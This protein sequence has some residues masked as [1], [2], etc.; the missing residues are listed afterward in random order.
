[1]RPTRLTTNFALTAAFGLALGAA[2]LTAPARA[3]EDGESLENKIFRNILEG[4]GL[5]KDG[6]AINY[7]E[8]PGLVIPPGRDLP[9]PDKGDAAIANNPAWPK[10]PD[11][12]RRKEEA[13]LERERNVSDER[14][15]E[16][17]RLSEKELTPGGN[18]RTPPSRRQ[19]NR[20]LG[21]SVDERGDRMTPS[22]L[23][24]K[25]GLFGNMFGSS[26]DEEMAKFTGERPRALLTDPP[27]GYQTPSPDQ[28]Y[29]L[30]GGDKD[31]SKSFDYLRDRSD[32]SL[33]R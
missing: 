6:E 29:G 13:R 14:E 22:E 12:A 21:S 19:V 18:P 10:D 8:R 24:Y 9:P 25:G 20:A 3:A 26:R 1:M 27:P 7:T 16:Q 33:T 23:G 28:P 32:P 2:L 5:R 31:K 11:I 15:R 4:I 17:N 30:V